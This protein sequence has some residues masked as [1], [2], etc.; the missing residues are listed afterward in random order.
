MYLLTYKKCDTY[1]RKICPADA[2]QNLDS[3]RS[4]Q[5][6]N[7]RRES[8]CSPTQLIGIN[9]LSFFDIPVVVTDWYY[10]RSCHV[11]TGRLVGSIGANDPTL[12]RCTK[13]AFY[14]IHG[15]ICFPFAFYSAGNFAL[16]QL[17]FQTI[18]HI[19]YHQTR[20]RLSL[21][22]HSQLTGRSRRAGP[23]SR[24]IEEMDLNTPFLF[25]AFQNGRSEG[26]VVPRYLSHPM[27]HAWA[28]S[29]K[30]LALNCLG[31]T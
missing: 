2:G 29:P 8:L 12:I 19:W 22:Q 10:R 21:H 4:N 5:R 30:V 17:P 11:R 14:S 9:F 31:T 20:Q 3:S 18:G 7:G 16:R 23:L 15:F 28:R 26:K 25:M 6:T 27:H 1:H 13:C 24:V